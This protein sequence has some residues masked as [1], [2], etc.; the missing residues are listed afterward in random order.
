[1]KHKSIFPSKTPIKTAKGNI[2]RYDAV[3]EQHWFN[4]VGYV[5]QDGIYYHGR[6]IWKF[7]TDM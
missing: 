7:Q 2:I 5:S 3:R 6:L 4:G 1:M